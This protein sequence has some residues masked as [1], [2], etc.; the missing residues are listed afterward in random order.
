MSLLTSLA[1]AASSSAQ[2]YEQLWKQVEAKNERDLP[3]SAL[4]SVEQILAKATNEQNSVQQLRA[5]LMKYLFE[6]E[7]SPDSAQLYLQQIEKTIAQEERPAVKALWH[8]ALAQCILAKSED[9][10]YYEDKSLTYEA[11]QKKARAH[12]EA[13]LS[14]LDV[15]AQ[16]HTKDFLPLFNEGPDSRYF[17]DDLLHIVWRSYAE[18]SL[19]TREEKVAWLSQLAAYYTEHHEPNA[20]LLL[21]LDRA[22]L[23]HGQSKVNLPLEENAFYQELSSLA[24]DNEML[25]A[26]VETYKRLVRLYNA[27]DHDAP[28]A[29][30]NTKLLYDAAQRGV[31]LYKKGTVAN[32]LRLF[33][34]T[35]SAPAARMG[36]IPQTSYPKAEIKLTVSLRHTRK[37]ELRFTPIAANDVE[38]HNEMQTSDEEKLIVRHAKESTSY[39]IKNLHTDAPVYAWTEQEAKVSLPSRPGVYAATLYVDGQ[40]IDSRIMRISRV[41]V[42]KFAT[43]G[44]HNRLIVV[45]SESGK[46]LPRA[47]VTA[48]TY[49]KNGK[50]RQLSRYTADEEGQMTII[51]SS[52]SYQ[53][54]R[55]LAT[56][57]NDGASEL[58]TLDNLRYYK[59]KDEKATT[60]VQLF[61]DRGIYRP[62]QKV[63]F[64]GVVFTRM[65][66]E[67]HTE[68]G[69]KMKVMLRNVNNKIV[70]SLNVCSDEF[71]TFSGEF[72]LPAACLPGRFVLEVKAK[73]LRGNT[74][75]Q[76]EEYKRP[77]FIATTNPLKGRYALGDSVQV[78]GQAK[79]YSGL[80]VPRA[81]VKYEVK[82]ISWFFRSNNEDIE[83]QE[84]IAHTDENGQFHLPVLLARSYDDEQPD[85]FDRFTYIVNYTITAENGETIQGSTSIGVATRPSWLELNV[86]QHIYRKEG[87]ML[88]TFQIRQLN[89]VGQNI[90]ATGKYALML[91]GREMDHGSFHT[92]QS[93][94]PEA[95]A[96]LPSGRYTLRAEVEGVTADTAQI[97]IFSDTDT[98]SPDHDVPFFFY[99]DKNANDTEVTALVGSPLQ[100]AIV[101]YDVVCGDSIVESR[102]VV[103]NNQLERFTLTYKDAYGDGATAF[104]AMMRNGQLYTENFSVKKPEPDKRL[105]L[106][107]SSF[108]SRLTPGQ[109]EEW[110]VKV[111]H[112]DG[113]PANAQLMACLYDASLDAFVK[114]DWGRFNVFFRRT[115]PNAWWQ[116]NVNSYRFTISGTGKYQRYTFRSLNF[117]A[118]DNRL[119]SYY[120]PFTYGICYEMAPLGAAPEPASVSPRKRMRLMASR[121][122]DLSKDD[123]VEMSTMKKESS[124]ADAGNANSSVPMQGVTPRTNF[125]ETAFFR[126]ALRT[127]A[128]GEVNITFTLPE[129]MTQ[130]NFTA[131]AHDREMRQGRLDTTVV[132]QKDFMVEP[133]LPRFLRQGDVTDLPVKVTNLTRKNVK[134]TL[135]LSLTNAE[136]GKNCYTH[137]QEVALQPGETRVYTFPYQSKNDEGVLV[138]RTV[139]HGSGFSDGE[140]H[141]LPVYN[142]DVEVIRSL[143][144]SMIQEGTLTLR[145][146]TL[147][148]T[149]EAHHRALSI[150][151][152]SNPTWYAVTALPSLAGTPDMHCSIDWATRLYALTLGQYVVKQN[153]EIRQLATS[154]RELNAL[155]RLQLQG[156]TDATPWLRQAESQQQQANSLSQI[157]DED[158]TAAHL[159]TALDKLRTLQTTDGSFSWYP[160]MQGNAYVTLEVA[161]LL[162]RIEKLTGYTGAHPLLSRS[163]GY[164][165]QWAA[166]E[167][168]EMKR[169]EAKA[170]RQFTPSESQ[171][172]YLYLRCLMDS[173]PDANATFLIDRA[174]KMHKELTMFG[175]ALTSIILDKADRKVEAQ[176]GMQSLME[177]T[178]SKPQMGRY[179]DT[180]RALSAYD[181]YRIPT[182]CAAIEAL[183]HFNQSA[184]ADEMRLWLL[185][186]KRTQMWE[187]KRASAEAI[188]ALL[189]DTT[190]VAND[191]QP[192]SNHAPLYYTLL[193]GERIV[194]LNARS[195][196]QAPTTAGYFKQSFTDA[197]ALKADAVKFTKQTKGLSWGSIYA[198][199]MAPASKVQ[200]EGNGL[201]IHRC[202]EVKC[203]SEW[204]P[205][206]ADITLKKGDRIRQIFTLTAERDFDFVRVSAARPACL[207]TAAPLSGYC[208]N[209]GMPAY[210]AVHDAFTDYFI[211]HL[212]K[213]THTFA[214]ELFIDRSG[215]FTTGIIETECVYSPE[216]RGSAAESTIRVQ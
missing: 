171:L 48:H 95:L 13:A 168:A 54:V 77:T 28:Y 196:T 152:S 64:S 147:F 129:S 97:L 8:A 47:I 203:G 172:R 84:G 183:R 158:M 205:V 109:Q 78:E 9:G 208:W 63:E 87:R 3:Q 138:C 202:Y 89:A 164:M 18:T 71:G 50:M 188:F 197:N 125:A 24:R 116:T 32:E 96:T 53:S 68:Q 27:Y 166:K 213:G 144:F 176:E 139:A 199:Y 119:F 122:N 124:F 101:Y 76:V 212:A 12:F 39:E 72:N 148:N 94:T 184:S 204:K 15:L 194:G 69:K 103:L 52:R 206:N 20:A 175:R 86:P 201:Q 45:D 192:L 67:Y 111:V 182:Q 149:K 108:R 178:V 40:R 214:E 180:Y 159:H 135:E 90:E 177:H 215:T 112:P 82:R 115:L 44:G 207:E 92:G 58:F 2:S 181:S 189:S 140:E 79:T 38:F 134:A 123:F 33:L 55:Y 60:S 157:F 93:F 195:Q 130:W 22:E 151:L 154:K 70:D 132:A 169:E 133:A 42:M 41:S 160:G 155:S 10:G 21:Q 110:R 4:Q 163:Y 1:L 34:S 145:T 126:P 198:S 187:S 120:L 104:I 11:T 179:F 98:K 118:W 26:N 46:P 161:T 156:L 61:S 137:L 35:M 57:N 162:A 25:E 23:L 88:P 80:P 174:A 105:L 153:P 200:T 127:N 7:I 14:D 193:C 107:W 167:V 74:S 16:A 5:T 211:E 51:E 185:Q 100:E 59:Q 131:L 73:S 102:R 85:R 173:R 49:D 114:H 66:D 99:A 186:A 31:N 6:E 136:S 165:Q 106:E 121:A 75:F 141:Y 62:G 170:K 29:Q 150:E 142:T 210:R 65:A 17:S 146:D 191:V 56:T 83:A 190:L 128:Q 216:F 117:S 43:P 91:N 113:S 209:N 19:L 143:P 37:A 81:E 30:H 36:M